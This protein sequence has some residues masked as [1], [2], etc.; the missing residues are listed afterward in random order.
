L[1][2]MPSMMPSG[3]SASISFRLPE[4]MNSFMGTSILHCQHCQ[5]C[6][7]CQNYE[8]RSRNLQRS[9]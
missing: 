3:T 1:V 4:S 6:Q 2:V 9:G 5:Y 8:E 7:N